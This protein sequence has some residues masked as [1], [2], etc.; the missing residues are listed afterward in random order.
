[1]LS[2]GKLAIVSC[3]VIIAK[4]MSILLYGLEACPINATDYKPLQHP[5]NNAFMKIFITKSNDIILD[6]QHE[7]DC[8]FYDRIACHK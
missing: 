5:V 1:M 7:F 6:C 8:V 4:Y 3:A 2:M